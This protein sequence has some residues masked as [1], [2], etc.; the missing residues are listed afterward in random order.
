MPKGGPPLLQ[1]TTTCAACLS[2]VQALAGA[3]EKILTPVIASEWWQVAGDPDLGSYTTEKQQPV[4]FAVWQAEDG[5]WQLWSCI[6]GTACGGHSRLFHR[7]EGEHLTDKHWTPKGIAMEADPSLGETPGGLQAPH[8]V[9][10]RG[11]YI[12]AYGDWVHICFATSQDGKTFERVIQP[13]GKTGVFSEGL[14]ANTRDPMLIRIGDLWYCYYTAFPHGKGYGYCR[15]S[16]DLKT[17]SHSC[18][19]SYGGKVGPGP[20]NNE[21]PHVVEPEPGTYYYFRNQFYGENATNWIYRSKNPLQFGI[22]NDEGL[23]RSWHVA[24]PEILFHEGQYYVASL[25]DSLKGIQIAR[26]NWVNVPLLGEAVFDLDDASFRESWTLKQGNL[27]GVFTRSK[28]A[29]FGATTTWF[30]GTAE[31]GDHRFDDDLTG[32]IESPPFQV[33]D[34]RYLLLVSGGNGPDRLYVALV[35]GDTHEEVVKVTG[36]GSNALERIPIDTAQLVGRKA[37]VRIV[38]QAQGGW[39]HINFGGVYRDPLLPYE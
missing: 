17:W 1:L 10:W 29:D 2:F 38:D 11:R 24:A 25:M 6:R 8:V 39:G 22:D 19:V 20:C 7:W 15:I 21:C 14:E 34:K 30:I 31:V 27:K 28:R 26:L 32:I 12:M 5:T 36:T 18:V 4:D 3:E 37:F 16:A 33:Q 23:V 13:K 9:K 35:D